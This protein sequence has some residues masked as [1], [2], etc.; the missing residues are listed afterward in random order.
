VKK[1][2]LEF[3][4]LTN[5]FEGRY[6]HKHGCGGEV[7]YQPWKVLIHVRSQQVDAA[8]M[9]SI[10][11]LKQSPLFRGLDEQTLQEMSHVLA[12]QTHPAKCDILPPAQT[13]ERFYVLTR[14]RVKITRS[15]EHDGRELTLWLLE[16]GDGFDIVSLLDGQPHVVSA[17]ALEEVETLSAPVPVLR[18]WLERYP[19]FRIAILRYVAQQLRELTE[20]AGSLALHDTMTR[21][22]HLLLRHY[23][24]NGVHLIHDLPHDELASMIGSVRVVV[25][26]LLARLKKEAVIE[27]HNGRLGVMN[28]KRLLRIAEKR[29]PAMRKA[30]RAKSA[31]T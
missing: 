17:W 15:N 8:C 23:D 24:G 4:R 11:A 9:Q 2:S 1:G 5:P 31:R 30:T 16:P 19:A 13:V 3:T 14:G 6:T 21:L 27:L 12:L 28:L 20:L 7:N 18:E 10:D 29:L 22:A 26:R 25:N